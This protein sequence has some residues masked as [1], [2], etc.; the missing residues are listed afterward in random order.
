[1]RTVVAT[2]LLLAGL[3]PTWADDDFSASKYL[4]DCREVVKVLDQ[5]SNGALG[6]IKCLGYLDAARVYLTIA[7]ALPFA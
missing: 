5:R 6:A 4:P 2:L 3:S 1:M 7:P